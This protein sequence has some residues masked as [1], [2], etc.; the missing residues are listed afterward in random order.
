MRVMIVSDTHGRHGALKVA[1]ER[2]KKGEGI[3]MLL[4]L[5]D[6]EGQEDYIEA[7]AECPVHIVRGN[8]DFFSSLPDE[9]EVQIGKHRVLLTHGHYYYVSMS[10]D[11]IRQEA[12]ERGCDT[13]MYGH[14]HKPHLDVGLGE[15]VTLI[16]PGSISY[17]RQN[18]RKCT[19]II[20]EVPEQ[21]DVRYNLKNV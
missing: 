14:T 16:N 11:R 1:L 20:M 13:V 19:Y 8:N 3:D 17:P 18:G 9:E 2:E 10:P 5:G 7:L 6:A 4:H 15:Q 12:K 21:G